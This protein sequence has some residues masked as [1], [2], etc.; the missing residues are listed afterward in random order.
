MCVASQRIIA[1][2]I[3]G[4]PSLAAARITGQT[5]DGKYPGTLH[6]C[7]AATQ[8]LLMHVGLQASHA[9]LLGARDLHGKHV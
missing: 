5:A 4:T 6:A 1:L 9:S 3:Q 7:L 2:C 8:N